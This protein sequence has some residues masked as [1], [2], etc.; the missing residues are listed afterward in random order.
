MKAR[1]FLAGIVLQTLFILGA[2][3]V[4]SPGKFSGTNMGGWLFIVGFI[5]CFTLLM[6][7]GFY[8]SGKQHAIRDL[9]PGES[10][11]VIGPYARPQTTDWDVMATRHDTPVLVKIGVDGNGA[12]E[13]ALI[14]K[15]DFPEGEHYLLINLKKGERIVYNQ[16]VESYVQASVSIDESK[17]TSV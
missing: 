13:L 14:R 5:F 3:F 8:F 1:W 7:A 11:V 17:P 10:G 9:E 6:L 16:P 2:M 4:V 12:L 15:K